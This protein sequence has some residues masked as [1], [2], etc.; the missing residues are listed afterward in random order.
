MASQQRFSQ[1]RELSAETCIRFDEQ[2]AKARSLPSR[3]LKT[4]LITSP[5]ASCGEGRVW[6][7]QEL[8]TEQHKYVCITHSGLWWVFYDSKYIVADL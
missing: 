4:W 5:G 2:L 1:S 6:W 8:L 3:K 7:L